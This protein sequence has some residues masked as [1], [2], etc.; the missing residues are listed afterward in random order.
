MRVAEHE[1]QQRKLSNVQAAQGDRLGLDI[2][3]CE[4]Q[5][6]RLTNATMR[7]YSCLACPGGCRRS[8]STPLEDGTRA[9]ARGPCHLTAQPGGLRDPYEGGSEYVLHGPDRL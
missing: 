9:A 2:R 6:R 8:R 4:D 3:S 7:R 1:C 5:V